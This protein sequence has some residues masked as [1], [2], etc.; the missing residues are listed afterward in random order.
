LT[1]TGSSFF[2]FVNLS[3]VLIIS[4]FIALPVLQFQATPTP[5][6][7]ADPAIEVCLHFYLY[8]SSTTVD[9]AGAPHQALLSVLV[10][11]CHIHVLREVDH[12]R[13][14]GLPLWRTASPGLPLSRLDSTNY[15]SAKGSGPPTARRWRARTA[16]RCG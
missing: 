12:F 4:E 8:F 2:G 15:S 5:Y 3:I 16:H 14:G 10:H 6:L 7:P 11:K 13:V 1:R 9:T